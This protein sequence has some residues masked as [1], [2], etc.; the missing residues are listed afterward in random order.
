MTFLHLVEGQVLLTN[1][2]LFRC[3]QKYL[4]DGDSKFR[5]FADD[6]AKGRNV[7]PA[8]LPA[9]GCLRCKPVPCGLAGGV[10]HVVLQE[11]LVCQKKAFEGMPRKAET[12]ARIY[13]VRL[14]FDDDGGHGKEKMYLLA[15]DEIKRVS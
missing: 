1:K 13:I 5:A 10:H 3:L 9:H 12:S 11:I 6:V 14:C 7:S 8:G 4:G 15:F 2:L